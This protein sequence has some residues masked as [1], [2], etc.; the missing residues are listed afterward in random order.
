MTARFDGASS[1]RG[2]STIAAHAHAARRPRHRA[3]R[4]RTTRSPRG[5]TSSSASTDAFVAV[6][7]VEHRAE[8]LAVVDHDVV[9]EDHRERL[10]AHVLAGD[11]DRVPEAERVA[12]A[13]VVDVG[14]LGD[15]LHLVRAGRA[16]PL[17]EECSSSKLR[18][19]WSSIAR[20]PRPVM[21]RMSVSPAA[22]RLLHHVLDRR[23]VDDRQHLLGL[24][25][26]G[27]EEPGAEARGGDD[28]LLA[29]GWS[30]R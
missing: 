18:S 30:R 28:R 27:G 4:S 6:V 20:L 29:R 19:K 15:V 22:H 9:A 16:C 5:A 25:L 2:F 23:L 26:R 7:H 14:E 1:G 11:A 21:I 17:L 10:V 3:R 12:L 13:D 8:Q 24:A